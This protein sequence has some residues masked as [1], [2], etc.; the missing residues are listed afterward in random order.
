MA[1]FNV[2]SEENSPLSNMNCMISLLSIKRIIVA[3]KIAAIES[4]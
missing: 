3:G 1:V 4:L 2:D